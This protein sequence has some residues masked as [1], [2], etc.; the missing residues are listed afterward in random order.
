MNWMRGFTCAWV[1]TVPNQ[2]KGILIAQNTWHTPTGNYSEVWDC[3][4]LRSLLRTSTIPSRENKKYNKVSE[5]FVILDLEFFVTWHLASSSEAVTTFIVWA[6]A[7]FANQTLNKGLIMRLYAVLMFAQLNLWTCFLRHMLTFSMTLC[8]PSSVLNAF[9]AYL[10]S[11][12]GH[13][14][15]VTFC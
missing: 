2:Q 6:A 5:T 9:L 12:V 10:S 4:F 1:S 8:L 11:N 13:S 14:V 7:L 15:P 3:F